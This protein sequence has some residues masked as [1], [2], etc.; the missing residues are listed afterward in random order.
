MVDNE[1]KIKDDIGNESIIGAE[2][3]MA[4]ECMMFE[5]QLDQLPKTIANYKE[6]WEIEDKMWNIKLDNFRP[7]DNQV[8]MKFEQDE[9]FW[10]C[11]EAMERYKYRQTKY[12]AEA[13]LDMYD[14]QREEAYVQLETMYAE[15]E[16]ME[17]E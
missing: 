6:Q 13:Q 2:N 5:N 14:K 3:S 15:I 16:K 10:E 12:Q 17:A 11:L 4:K 9:E 7:L 8:K 1:H